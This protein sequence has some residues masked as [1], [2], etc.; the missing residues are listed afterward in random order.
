MR[1]LL[2]LWVWA[3]GAGPWFRQVRREFELVLVASV[4]EDVIAT[5]CEG[6]G[7]AILSESIDGLVPWRARMRSDVS[8]A[9]GAG[10]ARRAEARVRNLYSAHEL[11][12][13][14]ARLPFP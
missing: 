7:G 10:R 11:S 5:A 2:L 6:T 8:D 1:V 14:R 12:I 3:R 13:V 4:K 9:D